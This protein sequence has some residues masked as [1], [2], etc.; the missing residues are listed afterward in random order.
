M[1]NRLLSILLIGCLTLNPV[2]VRLVAED[3]FDLCGSDQDPF[4]RDP[5]DECGYERRN[6][7]FTAQFVRINND[8]LKQV[9]TGAESASRNG[10]LDEFRRWISLSAQFV[11]FL[12]E[13]AHELG[14]SPYVRN[15]L[16]LEYSLARMVNGSSANGVLVAPQDVKRWL[17]LTTSHLFA[18]NVHILRQDMFRSL[19]IVGAGINVYWK[20]RGKL[21]TT[22]QDLVDDKDSGLNES[23]LRFEDACIRYTQDADFWKLRLGGGDGEDEPVRDFMPAIDYI[24][25]LKCSEVWFASTYS[26]KRKELY[27]RGYVRSSDIRCSCYLKG[28]VIHRG[29]REESLSRK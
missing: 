17:P 25:G 22:L 1:N 23:D 18:G 9:L 15:R 13:N 6:I 27:E 5:V 12:E 19:L 16:R 29:R 11:A 28:G 4:R 3:R 20:N 24:M 26:Q 8:W 14:S 21:P 2:S 10:N 7:D